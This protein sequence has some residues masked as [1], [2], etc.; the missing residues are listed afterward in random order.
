[1]QLALPLPIYI[2]L[3]HFDD[4]PDLELE[5]GLVVRVRHSGL[6][7]LGESRQ[8]SLDIRA[9]RRRHRRRRS[10]RRRQGRRR[11]RGR[12]L[13]PVQASRDRLIERR[14]RAR[15][16]SALG[17]DAVV[18]AHVVLF[19]VLLDVGHWDQARLAQIIPRCPPLLLVLGNDCENFT[20]KWNE[21]WKN[22]LKET[23]TLNVPFLKG[24]SS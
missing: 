15:A 4:V 14:V 9:P 19:F 16:F 13:L 22:C 21:R 7:D 8:R 10:R 23:I 6:F 12:R 5:R 3:G 11:G 1:M 2:S 18:V 17:P 20:C 24:K